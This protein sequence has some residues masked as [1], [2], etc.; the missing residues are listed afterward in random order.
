MNEIMEEM[1]PLQQGLPSLTMIPREWPLVIIDLKYCFFSIPL[2]PSDAH[3]MAFSV[4]SLNREEPLERYHWVVLPQG[5]KNSPTIC[6]W[7]V[8]RALAPARKKYLEARIIHY[9]DDL[10]IAAS[11]QQ[12]LQQVR[13]C[14]TEEVQKAGL[15]IST[16]KIQEIAPW[17]YLG[18]KITE[19]TIKPQKIEISSK[20]NNLQDLQQLL[21][22]INWMR[23]ILGI[24]NE[25][26]SSLFNLLRG[27]SNIKSPRTLTPEAQK[28]LE[29]VA[30]IIQQRQAHRY[31]DSLPFCLAMLGEQTQLYGLIFQW[32]VSQRD[33]LLIIEW[34]FLSYRSP[35][36]I[37]ASLEMTAQIIIKARTRLL[38]MTGKD[39]S[40]IYLPLKKQYFDWANQKSQDLAIALLDYTGICTIHY[41]SHRMLKA[42]VSFREKPKI[43]EE[44]LEGITVFTDG[45]G[46]THKSVIT[47]QNSAT[48][49]WESDVK[50]VQG[51]PQIV[52]LAAVVRVF[53]LF[54][55]PLN[56]IT[57]SAYV[58]NVVKR[59]EGSLLRETSNEI[60]YSYLSCMKTLLE[61]RAHKY[62]ITHIRAHSS[63]PGLLAEGN[64]QAD[65]LTMSVLQTLPDIFEQ[66]K[67]SH[68]FF[69]QNARALMESFHISKSQAKE[70][71]QSCPDC[72]L[73]Q[74]PTST[75][76]VNPRGLQSLQ[77]WQTDV[78]KYLSFGKLKNIHVSVDTFSGAI[79]ASLC[80]GE[81]V[82]HAC[83][84]FLQAFASLGVP[85]E[86]KTDNGPTYIGKV[87]DKFLKKWGVRHAFG[88]PHSPTGQA[89]IER[90][91]HALKTL[92]D[93]QKRGE[94]EATPHMRLNKAL[95]ILNFLNGSFSEPTP[96]IIRH[97]TNDT[98]AK[99]KENPL[100]LIRNPEISR[101]EGPFKLITWGKGFACVSTERG[102]KWVPARNVKPYRVQ[103]QADTVPGGGE[104][105]SRTEPEA[106]IMNSS[107]D[108]T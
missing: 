11:T 90:T 30:E 21:G 34:I 27:D 107:S 97:F 98:R 89:I 86:V 56:L 14:V 45:S 82:Q 23:P 22:E 105:S 36:T 59:L 106:E 58:A 25:D 7:Y 3:R 31:V 10:L 28:A 73:V 57:D 93:K 38:T 29:R 66:A 101:I 33:P 18:W 50:I 8:A 108:N 51:S 55:Q 32:D 5:L 74:P 72:Q 71:I 47:W 103:T 13:D 49:E 61:N 81:T 46:K 75:G 19:Q 60:L 92:L 12:E 95:Y 84:H 43:S 64:A 52:E 94:A 1:G 104:E 2:H 42:K 62:F 41:P 9:M 63:L 78:T 69:H 17:K 100:V 70:I 76:A 77:L 87:L 4:P 16:S 26:L 20:I 65:R 67:L 99:I 88:I 44:P 79:F 6:Q 15:E 96:P 68:A 83:R 80:T 39:F 40:V 37:L 91:H 53:E 24:T 48:G 85:Q 102:P 54:Q 35:K